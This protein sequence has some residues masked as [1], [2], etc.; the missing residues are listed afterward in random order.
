MIRAFTTLRGEAVVAETL[1]S[2]PSSAGF[3]APSAR[4]TLRADDARVLGRITIGGASGDGR[5]AYSESGGPVFVVSSQV[6]EQIPPKSTFEVKTP[7][8]G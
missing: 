3:V 2:A 7:P 6:L 5:Y 1:S 4:V 8:S